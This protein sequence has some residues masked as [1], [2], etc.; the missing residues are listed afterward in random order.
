MSVPDRTDPDVVKVHVTPRGGLYVHEREL[1]RSTGA[2]E[3]M[4][5]MDRILQ[6]EIIDGGG[7]ER[8]QVGRQAGER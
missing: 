2:R 8:P 3:M 5:K 7:S 6:R 4:A 1:L